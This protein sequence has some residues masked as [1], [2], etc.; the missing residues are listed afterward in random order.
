[1]SL[2]TLLGTGATVW[3]VAAKR[4]GPIGGLAAAAVF[5]TGYVY[6]RPWLDEHAPVLTGI[7]E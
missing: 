2:V 5:V 7:V 6:L 1:M 3:K 4:F